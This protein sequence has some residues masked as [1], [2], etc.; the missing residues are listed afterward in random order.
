MK[1]IQ[2]GDEI[3]RVSNEV[4]DSKVGVNWQYAPKSAWKE[5]VRDL[6]KNMEQLIQSAKKKGNKM[7]P[8]NNKPKGKK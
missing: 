8:P 6:N 4:A 3:Q 2:K 5:K 1:T 7:P